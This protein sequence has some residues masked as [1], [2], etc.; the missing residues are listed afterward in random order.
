VLDENCLKTRFE[1]AKKC[2]AIEEANSMCL[3]TATPEG[4]PSNRMVLLKSYGDPKLPG[5]G[6]VFFT[7]YDSRKAKELDSNPFASLVFYW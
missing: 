4:R 3:A 5:G 1:N 6:F 7:N 2:E